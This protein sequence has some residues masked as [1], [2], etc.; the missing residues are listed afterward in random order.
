MCH[1]GLLSWCGRKLKMNGT[2][3][4][5]FL[6]SHGVAVEEIFVRAVKMVNWLLLTVAG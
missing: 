5:C 4:D 6:S 3:F 1:G 2:F